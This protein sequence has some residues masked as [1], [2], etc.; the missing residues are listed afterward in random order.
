MCKEKTQSIQI[1]AQGTARNQIQVPLFGRFHCRLAS[2]WLASND[3]AA[4]TQIIRLNSP[5]FRLKHSS[6]V[7][8]S[9]AGVIQSA[10]S[11]QPYPVFISNNYAQISGI[12]GSVEWD[13]E[14]H[15]TIELQLE[16][17]IWPV[18]HNDVCVITINVSP[19]E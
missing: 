15:G 14:F 4:A 2:V 19:I 5:Q 7:Q 12:E 18:D 16:S 8:Y 6:A 1:I 13:A 10:L 11:S 9:A 3:P 17:L